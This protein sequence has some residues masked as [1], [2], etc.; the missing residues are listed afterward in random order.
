MGFLLHIG[1]VQYAHDE[2]VAVLGRLE[3][4]QEQIARR[5][6]HQRVACRERRA[7]VGGD[8]QQAELRVARGAGIEPGQQRDPGI[9][10]PEA[11]R[12]GRGQRRPGVA[13]PVWRSIRDSH[14]TERSSVIAIDAV[15]C[16]LGLVQPRRD[17]GEVVALTHPWCGNVVGAGCSHAEPSRAPSFVSAMSNVVEAW[18]DSTGPPVG[19]SI[20]SR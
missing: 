15:R 18:N 20:R 14:P 6:L 2:A 10:R 16:H 3:C 1:R 13:R 4:G 11:L 17:D 8:G 5:D 9:D 7:V 12:A 19:N